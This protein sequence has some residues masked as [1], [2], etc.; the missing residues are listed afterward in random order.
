MNGLKSKYWLHLITALLAVGVFCFWL[1][2]FPFVPVVREMAQLF[3]WT[4]DYFVERIVLPGGLAQYLQV[5]LVYLLFTY[6]TFTASPLRMS[7]NSCGV[8]VTGP[9]MNSGML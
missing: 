8:M 5:T 3:L 7:A 9:F 2:L 6:F 4:S 1:F